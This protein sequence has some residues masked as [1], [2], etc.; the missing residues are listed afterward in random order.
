MRRYIFSLMLMLISPSLVVADPVL[1]QRQGWNTDFS[2]SLIQ[3]EE[4]LSGGPP[5]DG[6]PSIDKPA[7][8]PAKDI[9][10]IA[11]TEPVIRLAYQGIV[12]A[13]PLGIM[14]WHEI[15]NDSFDSLPVVVT[16]CPLCNSAIAFDGRIDGKAHQFGTTGKLR[17]SDLVMY[18]RQTDSWWQ[19]FTGRSIIGI[20]AGTRLNMIPVRIQSFAEFQSENPDGD[21]LVPNNPGFRAYGN[22]P[23]V[24]YDT[25]KSPFLYR[26][27]LPDNIEP[28]ARVV[29]INAQTSPKAVTLEKIRNDGEILIDGVTVRWKAGVNSALDK[30]EIS[31]GRDVGGVQTTTN[32]S[33]EQVDVVH[34]Q[35]FAFVFHAFHPDGEIIQ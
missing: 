24:S 16:Y 17:N 33:G 23:Y 30:Q 29:V 20:Y 12:R 11:P 26:G 7:F 10:D 1:W 31:E 13:Y 8:K 9:T 32:V 18:D 28:M 4:I 3:F 21:V 25:S 27:T 22:N 6:I 35:T 2:K 34:D 19:Q 14:I 5:R 15:V